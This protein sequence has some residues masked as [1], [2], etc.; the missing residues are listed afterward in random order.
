M[1]HFVTAVLIPSAIGNN[2][3]QLESYL[4]QT[5]APFDE[6][7]EVEE[8]DRDCHCIGNVASREARERADKE[9]GT[10]E[11]LRA[12]FSTLVLTD[13]RCVGDIQKRNHELMFKRNLSDDEKDEYASTDTELDNLW[14]SH[15]KARTDAEKEYF[16]A[17]PMK[18]SPDPTC[19]FYSGKRCDWWPADAKE[20]D[21]Y[22]DESGCG[23]T[24]TYRSTY[25]PQS[26]WDW[27]VIGG[28]WN[29][30]LAPP[31]A[32]PEKDPDN[33]KTCWLCQGTGMRNDEI[34]RQT[35]EENPE[36]TCNG[37]GGKGKSLVWPTEQK[38]SGYNIVSPRYIESLGLLGDLPTPYAFIDLEG[39]WH[40]KGKM[41]WFGMSS[42]EVEKDAW[43]AEWRQALSDVSDGM[44]GFLVVVVDMHI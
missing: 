34:G 8:Y 39:S 35:R 6:N 13:G 22:N 44:D 41:G 27:W 38:D 40:Q 10:I 43:Q 18:D 24:G 32:Q 9:F 2:H 12:T 28:R 25:N 3:Q 17:H 19:G 30:W 42:D 23:A 26:K 31:E 15:L 29:G 16:E 4:E 33:W 7:L 21:R 37:C 11:E 5:L 1:S 14:K 20:G 36:Y